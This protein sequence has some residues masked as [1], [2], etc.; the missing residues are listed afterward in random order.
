VEHD[1]G[2]GSTHSGTTLLSHS[3]LSPFGTFH[4]L[5]YQC[6]L[7]RQLLGSER[8]VATGGTREPVH[9]SGSYALGFRGWPS[10][11]LKPPV[12]NQLRLDPILI[13]T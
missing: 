6:L 13:R 3:P 4:I 11:G 12:L 2:C 9:W 10:S 5:A 1:A 8:T 7:L